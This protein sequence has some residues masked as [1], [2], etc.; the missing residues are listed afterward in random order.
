[1]LFRSGFGA[2]ILESRLGD[3]IQ[4]ITTGSKSKQAMYQRLK[5]D[6]EDEALALPNHRRLI[7]ELTTLE[8][9]YTENGYLKISHPQ[10]GHDDYPDGLALANAARHGLDITS[11]PQ[12]EYTPGYFR[13]DLST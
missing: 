4:M 12:Q 8:Y 11:T 6:I 1:M 9:T 5:K 10:G 2:D 7:R 3:V 13:V